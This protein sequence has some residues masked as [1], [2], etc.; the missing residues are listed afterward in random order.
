MSFDA[1]R[2]QAAHVGLFETPILHGRLQGADGLDT[3]LAAVK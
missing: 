2:L 1:I 3:E